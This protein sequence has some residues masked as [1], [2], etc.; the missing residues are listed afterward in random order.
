[1]SSQSSSGVFEAKGGALRLN[2]AVFAAGIATFVNMYC[3]MSILPVLGRAF[4]VSEAATGLTVTAPLLATAM[5]APVIGAISDRF[6][7]RRL[8]LGAAVLLV[9]PTVLAATAAS[10]HAFVLWRFVQGLMLPFIFTVTIAYIG[11]ETDGSATVK[12]AGTYMSGGIFGGFA[13]RAVS[14]FAAQ[15]FGWREALLLIAAITLLMAAVIGVCLRPE[16]RFSPVFGLAGALRAFPMHLRNPRLLATYGVGFGV[17]FCMIGVFTFVNFRLAAPPYNLGPAALGAIFAVYLAAVVATPL[18]AR[19]AARFGRRRV[20]LTAAP[21]TAVG[22]LC[23]LA[24]PLPV[25]VLGLLLICCAIF[26]QQTL[27]TAFVSTAARE[28]KSAAVGLYVTCY[29]IGGSAGG[30]VPAPFYHAFG[31]IGCVA[32]MA[33]MQGLML[34]LALRFWR[35]VTT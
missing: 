20:M 34:A 10:F 31:W 3:T 21:V 8:I 17:L 30:I 9:V 15:A 19:L 22:L 13:G 33:V 2:L 27:A 11:E 32:V 1:M 5:M 16:R 14:G 25:I 12:L 29:Y 24:A 7:R 26:V 18:A 23:T 35:P 28:A 6:G 4:G